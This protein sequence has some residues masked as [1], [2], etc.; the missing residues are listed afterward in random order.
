MEFSS[1]AIWSQRSLRACW[2]YMSIWWTAILSAPNSL[3]QFGGLGLEAVAAAEGDDAG[4]VGE[5]G[6][7]EGAA[8]EA[9]GSGEDGGLAFEGEEGVEGEVVGGD[10]HVCLR[11][12]RAMR[13]EADPPLRE[14]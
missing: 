11:G 4:S 13:R 12:S 6:E 14:G 9:G 7:G 5:Q 2:S 10:G 8:E 1:A 3:A